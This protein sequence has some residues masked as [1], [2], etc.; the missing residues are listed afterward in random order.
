MELR[1]Q[2]GRLP[3]RWRGRVGNPVGRQRLLEEGDHLLV[4]IHEVPGRPEVDWFFWTD[5]EG[6]WQSL[7][8]PG[9]LLHWKRLLEEYEVVVDELEAGLKKAVSVE[10]YY[11]ILQAEVA[12]GQPLKQVR[13]LAARVRRS[14]KKNR[15]LLE[16]RSIAEELDA[17]LCLVEDGARLGMEALAAESAEKQRRISEQQARLGLRLNYL[18]AFF[19]PLMALGTVFGMNV[20]TGFEDSRWVFG[21]IFA[22]G[23]LTGG[24]LLRFVG[25]R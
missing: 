4:L 19:L 14:R 13:L 10:D 20:P 7:P 25:H 11:R 23:L 24:I 12:V 16:I 8:E 9:G 17:D 3:E 5:D 1:E 15:Q 22:V 18:A 21:A 6:A 2:I